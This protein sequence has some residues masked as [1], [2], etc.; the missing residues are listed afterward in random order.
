ML[1]TISILVK[2][3]VQ[4]VYYRQ[5]TKEKAEHLRVTGQVKNQSD[6]SVYIVATGKEEQLT[7][8]I[9]WCYSGPSRAIVDS[10]ETQPLA[11]QNFDTF[12]IIRH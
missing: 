9:N 6:G 5:S 11:L 12:N 7:A 2:G 4:G 8:L 1:L 3:K 10:V